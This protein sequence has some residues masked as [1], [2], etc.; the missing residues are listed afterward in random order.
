MDHRVAH[1]RLVRICF[2]DYDREWAIVAEVKQK[3]ER[4]IIGI[5]RL[6]RIADTPFA[7]FKM[8]IIDAF[9]HLGLG[10][11][12]LDHLLHIAKQEKIS[13]VDGFILSENTIML[14][15]CEKLGFTLHQDK[16]PLITHVQWQRSS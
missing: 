9:H 1:E 13:R 12:L 15:I 8:S 6:T 7:Q 16:D 4:Q 2:N 5:G 14:K 3:K 10:K 11:Q